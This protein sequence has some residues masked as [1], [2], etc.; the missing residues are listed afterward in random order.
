MIKDPVLARLE[1]KC[2]RALFWSGFAAVGLVL[3][4]VA[5]PA[6]TR[7]ASA[8][9]VRDVSPATTES[10]VVPY[11]RNFS[12]DQLFASDYDN[13]PNVVR[14]FY[15][16]PSWADLYVDE[17]SDTLEA[18]AGSQ[19]WEYIYSRPPG[20]HDAVM[21]HCIAN[22]QCGRHWN[23]RPVAFPPGTVFSVYI[24]GSG[25]LTRHHA[26]VVG[27][28]KNHEPAIWQGGPIADEMRCLA[29]SGAPAP[30]LNINGEVPVTPSFE[31]FS[32]PAAACLR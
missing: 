1:A 6:L 7:T 27:I 19:V 20:E 4:S 15:S 8:P 14:S 12:R 3:F 13:T 30:E 11:P 18:P 10:T 2:N 21:A 29:K 9:A 16:V 25:A 32:L 24:N 17:I 23:A 22:A 26:V 31:S 5:L 28:L